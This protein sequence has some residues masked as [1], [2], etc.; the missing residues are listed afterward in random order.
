MFII[1]YP[2][3]FFFLAIKFSLIRRS[4]Q[5]AEEFKLNFIPL[6]TDT[7]KKQLNKGTCVKINCKSVSL[8]KKY[9]FFSFLSSSNMT[10]S[11]FLI[12]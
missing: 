9:Y 12:L 2:F 1:I 3:D 11:P 4:P 6:Y 10:V 8:R 5:I 7:I